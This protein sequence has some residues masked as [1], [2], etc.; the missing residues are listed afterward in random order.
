MTMSESMSE[1]WTK[2]ECETCRGQ[3]Y[4]ETTVNE[5]GAYGPT[6]RDVTYRNSCP[7]C[8]GRGSLRVRKFET[9]SEKRERI[10][11]NKT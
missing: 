6:G 5:Q 10:K 9:I 7:V 8:K 11:K 4:W 3:G 1:E 2:E